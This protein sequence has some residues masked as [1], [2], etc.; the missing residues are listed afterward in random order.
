[1]SR[2]ITLLLTGAALLALAG[3]T[4]G[5]PAVAPND[6]V[7]AEDRTEEGAP[8]GGEQP[9][10]AVGTLIPFAASQQI[11][12]TQVPTEPVPAGPATFS[13]ACEG[14]E[15]NVVLEELNDLVT[16]ECDEAGDFTGEPVELAAGTYTYYCS[17]PGHRSNMQ[18]T[19]TVE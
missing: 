7:A 9:A 17:I 14:L 6:Q 8:T 4:P 16:V 12:Y 1:M 15:H 19:M 3:C 13:L 18:G 11:E 5:E 2:I 10:A